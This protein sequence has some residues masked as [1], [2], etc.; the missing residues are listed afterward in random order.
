MCLRRRAGFYVFYIEQML[1]NVWQAA[2]WIRLEVFQW[3]EAVSNQI[4]LWLKENTKTTNSV[5]LIFS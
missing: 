5:T 4:T 1:V 3:G 2:Y